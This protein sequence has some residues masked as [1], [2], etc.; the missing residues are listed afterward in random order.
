MAYPIEYQIVDYGTA[1]TY[2]NKY[3]IGH[4]TANP[5]STIDGEVK[6]MKVNADNAFVS[7]FVGGG[8][9]II[10]TAPV[11]KVQW[12]AGPKAN[13]YA[14]AQVELC[15]AKDQATFRKDYAAYIWLLR[16]LADEC[17]IPKNLDSAGNGIKTHLWVT[18]NLGGTDHTD[19]YSYLNSMGISN[20][21]FAQDVAN[22]IDV[23]AKE[24]PWTKKHGRFTP[25]GDTGF[26]RDHPIVSLNASGVYKAGESVEYDSWGF[27]GEFTWIH[28]I[29]NGDCYMITGR[30]SDDWG[31]IEDL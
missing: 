17:G 11:G 28:W 23:S 30:P 4:E 10:Q 25:Y 7:H 2:S 12:G 9:R 20:A 22:G 27:D 19:P 26:V 6:Y 5:N 29:D 15:R 14:Y 18:N 1:K 31:F 21:Q 13:G 8:G 16:M 24:F 3:V